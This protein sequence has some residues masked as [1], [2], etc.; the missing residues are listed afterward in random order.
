MSTTVSSW[1]MAPS[2]YTALGRGNYQYDIIGDVPYGVVDGTE[3]RD[4]SE[5]LDLLALADTPFINRIG[6]GPE[7]GGTTIEWISENLGPGILKL[8]STVASEWTSFVVTSVNG[9]TASDT[10]YQIKQGSVLY[11]WSSTAGDHC[12]AVVTS[13]KATG[14]TGVSVFISYLTAGHGNALMSLP[15]SISSNEC[16]YVVGAFA[17]EGSTPNTPMPRPRTVCSNNF[18]ILRQDVQIT[19]TM[20]STDMYAIGRED[21]HQIMLR[22]KELQRERERACLYSASI[23]KTTAMAG[24]MNGCLGFLGLYP[25]G[26]NIDTS[27]TSLTE[28]AVNTVITAIWEAGGRN[29]T[30]F[31]HINQTAKFTRWDKNRIRMRVNDRKGGGLITSYLTE[32]GIEIDLIPMANVPTNLAF[33]IDT[34]K[35][36]L[37]AKRGRKAIMEKLGKMGDFDDWQII[38]EFSMEMKG[39]N[40]MQH[41][42]FERLT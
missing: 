3:R 21:R 20:K 17:N 34:S 29:L 25:N 4:V 36:R 18:T 7:S 41:G 23:T 13:H 35:V 28:A 10:L 2:E 40:L 22:L 11:H 15:C 30:F 16:F 26:D 33:I 24:L 27:T 38:S 12:L 9:I 8:A 1:A 39:F 42:M 37:R 5:A 32:S 14:G 19:G 6:W 31:G